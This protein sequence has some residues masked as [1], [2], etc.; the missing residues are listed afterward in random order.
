M[1][2]TI[3]FFALVLL[4]AGCGGDDGSSGSE[5]YANTVCGD[6]SSWVADMQDTVKSLTDAGLSTDQDD[7]KAAFDDAKDSTETMIR[8]LGELDPPATDAGT[9]AKSGLDS[10]GSQLH[11]QLDTME[12]ALN[13]S[14][15]PLTQ[16]STITAA[17]SAA[18]KEVQST[19]NELKGLDPA[20]ELQDAFENAEDCKTL[21]DQLDEIG[22]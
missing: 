13:G 10:L 17:I 9:K 22:S 6:V 2:R 18:T 20:G 4:L 7:L 8:D 19:Y 5:E 1:N 3:G 21:S 14:A 16:L 15:P 12:Q 11:Q